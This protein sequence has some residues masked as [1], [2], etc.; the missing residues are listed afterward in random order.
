VPLFPADVPDN[1]D[2][3]PCTWYRYKDPRD[4]PERFWERYGIS[5][6]RRGRTV[7]PGATP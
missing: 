3:D 6:G 2:A 1:F 4:I 5:S 7:D